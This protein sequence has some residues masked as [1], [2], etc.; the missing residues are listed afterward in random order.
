MRKPSRHRDN[1]KNKRIGESPAGVNLARVADAIQYTGSPYHKDIPSFAGRVQP[2]R[3]DASVCPRALARQQSRILDW[4]R[5]AIRV[6]HFSGYWEG[7]FPRYVWHRQGDTVYEGRL[8]NSGTG[9]YHG[10]PLESDQQVEG[11]P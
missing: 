2:P 3:P 4:L 6:G 1:P 5:A 9:E 11:L 7:G 8:T 10:Y